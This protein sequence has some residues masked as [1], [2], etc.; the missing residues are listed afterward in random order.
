[1]KKKDLWKLMVREN[2]LLFKRPRLKLKWLLLA[3]VGFAMVSIA[4]VGAAIWA[5]SQVMPE[6]E[7]VARMSDQAQT[8]VS[9]QLSAADA[10]LRAAPATELCRQEIGRLVALS[11]ATAP[12]ELPALTRFVAQA[13][14]TLPD[15]LKT[16]KLES[17]SACA[18]AENADECAQALGRLQGGAQLYLASLERNPAAGILP[19]LRKWI[20]EIS[21]TALELLRL[22]N[23]LGG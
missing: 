20:N 17:R 14:P 11:P 7:K 22:S 12:R 1:M 4:L 21:P 10:S 5:L 2:D 9:S 16:L 13:C 18:V 19:E 6:R 15:E 8:W 23:T 3:G